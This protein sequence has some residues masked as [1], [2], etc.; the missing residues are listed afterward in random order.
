MD[1]EGCRGVGLGVTG[2]SVEGCRSLGVGGGGC[3]GLGV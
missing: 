3:R 2:L 1:V